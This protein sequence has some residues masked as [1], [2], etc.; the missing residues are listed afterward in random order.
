MVARPLPGFV[1]TNEPKTHP[2]PFASTKKKGQLNEPA[3]LYSNCN[4]LQ[5]GD[6]FQK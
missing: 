3:L 5:T 4:G 6:A 2:V 1:N